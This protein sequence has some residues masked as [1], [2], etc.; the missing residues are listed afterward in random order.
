MIGKLVALVVGLFLFAAPCPPGLA[1]EVRDDEKGTY[2]GALFSPRL[3]RQAGVVVTHVIPG[4]PAAQA[5]LRRND[6]LLR[7]NRQP[8]RDGDHLANLICADKPDRKVQF[9]I[10]RGGKR[11]TIETTLALG[12]VLKLSSASR[13]G[14]S[15]PTERLRMPRRATSPAA[16]TL[17]AAPQ[18]SGKMRLTIEYYEA[19]KLQVVTCEG[20]AAELATTVEKLPQRERDLVR[21]ALER[22]NKL[23]SEKPPIRR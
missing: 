13:H 20:V 1:A 19:G 9:L 18:V 11:Q 10:L 15:D 3:E 5:D 14:A 8:I 23:N 22:L 7:Y 16:V 12:P 2:L 21:I 17:Y 6:I 4:S